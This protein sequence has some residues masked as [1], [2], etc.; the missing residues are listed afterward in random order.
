VASLILN[1]ALLAQLLYNRIRRIHSILAH[2]LLTFVAGRADRD[3][4]KAKK[5]NKRNKKRKA[6]TTRDKSKRKRSRETS[7]SSESSSRSR[8]KKK[9]DREDST[10]SDSSEKCSEDRRKML[11][12]LTKEPQTAKQICQL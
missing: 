2:D 6:E 11:H 3:K 7:H 4:E 5:S 1:S 10:E 12:S 9:R 8:S